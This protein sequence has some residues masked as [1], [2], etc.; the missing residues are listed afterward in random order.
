[1]SCYRTPLFFL[2]LV[3]VAACSGASKG[4]ERSAVADT[5]GEA[6]VIASSRQF[7]TS[8]RLLIEEYIRRDGDGERLRSSAWFD[9]VLVA[10][11]REPGYDS[12][13]AIA[14]YEVESVAVVADTALVEV[15][16]ATI[17]SVVQRVERDQTTGLVLNANPARESVVFRVV[18]TPN[19]L[20]IDSPQIDQHVLARSILASS[21]LP[22]FSEADRRAL[23]RPIQ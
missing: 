9:S 13:T 16:Y 18:A 7:P 2:A 14:S 12:F 1:M 15:R 11:E 4:G 5:V 19:G 23:Q 22:P 21:N 3:G 10:P 20:R 8:A 6:R 17:G